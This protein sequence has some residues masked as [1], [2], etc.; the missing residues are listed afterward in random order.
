[1]KKWSVFLLYLLATQLFAGLKPVGSINPQYDHPSLNF[2][3]VAVS[4]LD[5]IYLLESINHE[6]YRLDMDGKIIKRTGGLGWDHYNLNTPT[7]LCLD[8]GLNIIVAD[9]NNNRVVRYD[10]NINFLSIFPDENKEFRLQYPKSLEM[11]RD[12]ILFILQE[13]IPEIMKLDPDENRFYSVGMAVSKNY[14]LINPV[15][16][17]LTKSEELLVLEKSGKILSFD[18]YGTAVKIYHLKIEHFIP[19]KVLLFHDHIFLISQEFEL[20]ELINGNCEKHSL[21]WFV[22]DFYLRDEHLYLLTQSGQILIYGF[23]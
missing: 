19:L 10:Q 8:A 18:R 3:S 17:F 11:T 1:M 9:K 6:L 23:K 2:T 21:E 16:I 15:D 13:N 12:G 14:E 20:F 4:N 22:T 7:D 5:N